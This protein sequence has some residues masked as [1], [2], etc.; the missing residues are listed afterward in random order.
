MVADEHSASTPRRAD[1][2]V[3]PAQGFKPRGTRADVDACLPPYLHPMSERYLG[4][5]LDGSFTTAEFLRWF[6]MPN[7]AYLPVALCV[8]ERLGVE[9]Q[10][11]WPPPRTLDPDDPSLPR[12][13]PP[14]TP[15]RR[16]PDTPV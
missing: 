13:A 15:G 14:L 6:H 4:Y 1:P 16:R 5:F 7:S 8:L 11:A 9:W 12:R 2:G 10:P 3:T